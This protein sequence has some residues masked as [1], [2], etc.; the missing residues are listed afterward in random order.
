MGW[1]TPDEEGTM[2]TERLSEGGGVDGEK[3][4]L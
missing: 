2:K 3:S 4:D 1:V